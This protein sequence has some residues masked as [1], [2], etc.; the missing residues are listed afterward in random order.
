MKGIILVGGSG[1]RL[2]PMT[3]G[4]N[5]HLLPV[6]DKPM[7]FYPLATLMQAGIRD[8]L[9]ITNPEDLATYQALLGDGAS[10]G[11]RL[12][13]AVQPR[14]EGIAQAFL[15]GETFLNGDGCALILGDNIF[16]GRALPSL[17]HRVGEHPTGATIF[18][19]Q[20]SNPEHF[21]V[22]TLDAEQRPI[23]LE[24]KP[25]QARS[26]WA[27]TGLY[28]YDSEVA[29]IAKSITPS[30]RGE[31]EITAVNKAYLQRGLLKVEALP[32]GTAWL[33][34]GTPDSLLQASLYVQQQV[35]QQ[36][37]QVACLDEIAFQQGF[38]DLH[39]FMANAQLYKN[40]A[41]G[42]YIAARAEV[43]Y[44]KSDGSPALRAAG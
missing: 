32:D 31:L 12:S 23:H 17:L 24:E 7:F 36:K 15:I 41:Y 28:F 44:A 3:N 21:G 16:D 8:I 38:I 18:A 2:R 26:N 39:R 40:T 22:V 11:L 9:F 20:V 37:R 1:T 19:T 29:A 30:P 14:P 27:V 13:Y 25:A 43:E 10:L 4:V 34:T 33:D 35:T 6:Y 5:K 42:A